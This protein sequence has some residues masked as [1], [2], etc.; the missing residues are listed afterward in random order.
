MGDCEPSVPLME[1]EENLIAAAQNIVKA[2]GSNRT[3]TDDARKILADLGS[4]LS[5]ITRVSETQDE[6][7]E[8]Q[9][10][11][12]EEELNLV[13]GKVMNWEVGKSMIWDCGQEE[14]YEYLRYVDQARK[15]IERFESS[16]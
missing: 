15:L 14:A 5:S 11:E 1:E 2:L 13:Q 16:D 3:L 9:L 10:I 6:G 12:M 7:D 4:Q 8:E